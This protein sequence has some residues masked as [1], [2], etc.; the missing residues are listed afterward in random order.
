[1]TAQTAE[2]AIAGTLHNG[3]MI[4]ASTGQVYRPSGIVALVPDLTPVE[5]RPKPARKVRRCEG[6]LTT[7]DRKG[8]PVVVQTPDGHTVFCH[9]P[10]GLAG[11][12]PRARRGLRYCSDECQRRGQRHGR[13]TETYDYARMAKRI[14]TK[15]GNRVADAD[16]DALA[17]MAEVAQAADAALHAAVAGIRASRPDVSWA[18]I[19][20]MLGI[21]RQAAQ[22][23]FGK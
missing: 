7:V 9:R 21:T 5:V 18:V 17:D 23:R 6:P 1:M 15:L 2:I 3:T 20:D 16:F 19:G 10:L 4:D 14:V 8:R 22:Q 12:D 13:V 11:T